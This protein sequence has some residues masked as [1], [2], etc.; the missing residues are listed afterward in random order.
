MMFVVRKLAELLRNLTLTIDEV[1]VKLASQTGVGELHCDWRPV[2]PS[3]FV[4]GFRLR[5]S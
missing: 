5:S 2:T 4:D 1:R 3:A